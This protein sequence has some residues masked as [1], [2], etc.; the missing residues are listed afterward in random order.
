MV[1]IFDELYYI[2]PEKDKIYAQIK[3]LELL[4]VFTVIPFDNKSRKKVY[5]EKKAN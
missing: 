3:V 1:H 5:L 4:H 2:N